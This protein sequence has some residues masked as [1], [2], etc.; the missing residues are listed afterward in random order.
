M[1]AILEELVSIAIKNC[2]YQVELDSSCR[3]IFF[4]GYKRA[5]RKVKQDYGKC[6]CY[7]FR[8]GGVDFA[9]AEVNR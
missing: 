8:Y 2:K 5:E 4:Y 1:L 9:F 3:D 7:A 6:T